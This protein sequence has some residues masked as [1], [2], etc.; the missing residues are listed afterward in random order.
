MQVRDWVYF[1]HRDGVERIVEEDQHQAGK[2][3]QLN[4]QNSIGVIELPIPPEED[5]GSDDRNEAV[6][7]PDDDGEVSKCRAHG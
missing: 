5:D 3:D 2:G 7:S 4:F 6:N 1:K